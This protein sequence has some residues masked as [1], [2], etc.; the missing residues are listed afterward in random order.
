MGI[1]ASLD[2]VLFCNTTTKYSVLRMK[3]DDTSIPE[4]ARSPYRY[5]DHLIRFTAVGYEI[6]QTETVK[7]E[8]IGEWKNGKYG[9][10]TQSVR[11]VV[12]QYDGLVEF[13]QTDQSFRVSVILPL[14]AGN[15]QST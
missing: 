7:L 6:P 1:V 13:D 11:N 12:S 10:G 9:L 2:K 15:A 14:P 8:L 5:H 3:T 4:D